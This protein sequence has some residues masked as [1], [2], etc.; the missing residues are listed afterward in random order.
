M[1]SVAEVTAWLAERGIRARFFAEPTPTAESAARAVG[2][3][4]AEI[5]KS[6]LFIVGQSPVLVVTSGDRKIRGGLLK[7]ATGLSGKVRLP[8][9][10]E[11]NRFTGFAPGGVCPFLLP[12]SLPVL[13]DR[14]LWRFAT[15]YPAAGNDHSAVPLTPD[16]LLQ[17]ADGR[18]VEICSSLE[19]PAG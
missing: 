18:P 13:V 11:V 15:V 16:Q 17:L 14:S 5:A 12:S 7:Q 1:P 8:R 9:G 2:C 10:E 3:S 4:A 6:I 19:V